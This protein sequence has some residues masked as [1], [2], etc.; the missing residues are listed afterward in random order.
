MNLNNNVISASSTEIHRENLS[1]SSENLNLTSQSNF[2]R[3]PTTP[4]RFRSKS[5]MDLKEFARPLSFPHNHFKRKSKQIDEKNLQ[6]IH[7]D[8]EDEALEDEVEDKL[9]QLQSSIQHHHQLAP[10]APL[11]NPLWRATTPTSDLP[12]G[13]VPNEA[14]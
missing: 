6:Q 2:Q 10:N 8:S 12:Y 5:E 13:V 14:G 7:F 1:V 3:I 4:V 11:V 9:G